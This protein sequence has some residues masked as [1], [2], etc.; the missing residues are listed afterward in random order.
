MIETPF[1]SVD[2]IVELYDQNDRFKGLVL[3]ERKNPPF[4]WALPGGFVDIGETVS[5]ALKREMF[6]EITLEVEIE[7]FLGLFSNPNRDSRFHTVTSVFVCRAYGTPK[8][9]DDAKTVHVTAKAE[10]LSKSL[11]FDHH[12]ILQ[13][14]LEGKT[15]VIA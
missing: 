8:A 4:G 1:L 6:E 10:A 7:R 9:A 13:D 12:R 14:Y 3:I 11:V 5:D 2:G 15:C